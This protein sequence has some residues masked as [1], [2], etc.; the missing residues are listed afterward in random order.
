MV[1]YPHMN[2][3]F[4]W[5]GKT[6]KG[7]LRPVSGAG[8]LYHLMVKNFYQGQMTKTETGWQFSSQ[9]YGYLEAISNELLQ[10]IISE[11]S[12]D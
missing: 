6:Y 4:T 11:K 12:S 10:F 8:T 5:N 2:V 3:D 9:K 1:K 7:E